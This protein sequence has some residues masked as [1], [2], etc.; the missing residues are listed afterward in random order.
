MKKNQAHEEC[1]WK[2]KYHDLLEILESGA[3]L[4]DIERISRFKDQVNREVANVSKCDHQ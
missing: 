3:N 2:R 4:F 1:F